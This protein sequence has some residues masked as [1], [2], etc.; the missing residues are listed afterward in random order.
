M[1]IR[2]FDNNIRNTF[3]KPEEVVMCYYE[4][5]TSAKTQNRHMEDRTPEER[6]KFMESLFPQQKHSL[7]YI[8]KGILP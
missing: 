3:R 7:A 6:V 2:R 1:S 8:M 4:K 5:D